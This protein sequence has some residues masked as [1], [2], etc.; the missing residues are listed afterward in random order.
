MT[1]QAAYD[2]AGT[3]TAYAAAERITWSQARYRL[4]SVGVR[5]RPRGRPRTRG[6]ST[7]TTSSRILAPKAATAP[8]G[9]A[10]FTMSQETSDAH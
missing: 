2:A 10:A 8:Q 7:P 9:V 3:I 6:I 1:R 5:L 4:H